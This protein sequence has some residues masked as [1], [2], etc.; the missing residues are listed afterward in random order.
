MF[1]REK[2]AERPQID[3][4]GDCPSY[5]KHI[6]SFGIRIEAQFEVLES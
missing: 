4:K 3:L 1:N 5:F 2:S 6:L